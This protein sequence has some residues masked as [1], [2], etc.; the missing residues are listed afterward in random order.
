MGD[1]GTENATQHVKLVDDDVVQS[2]QKGGPLAVVGQQAVMQHLRV[3]QDHVCVGPGPGPL[4][5][6]SVTVV[7][8][9]LEIRDVHLA[10]GSE[11]ILRQR[12]RRVEQQRGAGPQ[13]ADNG[14]GDGNL[15]TQ[16][17]AGGRASGDHHRLLVS[18]E[19]YR[20]CLMGVDPF[21]KAVGDL[22][23]Q[24]SGQLFVDRRPGRE[25]F[26][27]DQSAVVAKLLDGVVDGRR[28]NQ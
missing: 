26:K 3:G 2:L 25:P 20:F 13:T 21:G 23:R 12:F 8:D 10:E 18:N 11:L 5:L 19:V 14:L 22:V 7:G 24:R 15:E 9:G 17:L 28:Q 16:R 1:V 4:I 27:M 6:G